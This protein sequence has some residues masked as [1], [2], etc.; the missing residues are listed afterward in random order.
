MTAIANLTDDAAPL[1]VEVGDVRVSAIPSAK[2]NPTV[3]LHVAGV[4]VHMHC[5]ALANATQR[6][7][8]AAFV[9]AHRDAVAAALL[10]LAEQY[11]SRPAASEKPDTA[12]VVVADVEPWRHPVDVAEVLDL[13]RARIETHVHLPPH[14]AAV[15]AG[16]LLLT[17]L[18]DVL[19]TAPILWVYSPMKGCGKS[20]LLDLLTLLAARALKAENA[21]LSALFR[22]AERHRATLI[23]DEIDQ[24]MHG[25]RRSDVAGLLN[26]GFSVGGRFLRSVGD[27]HEPKA[28]NVFG[29]RAVAGIGATLHDT[30]RSRSYRVP[31][32]RAPAGALPVALQPTH[33]GA[34]ADPLRQH[35]ARAALQLSEGMAA[36][37]RDPDATAY[38]ASF[39]GRARDLWLPLLALGAELG[40]PWEMRFRD[41]CLA[42]THAAASDVTDVGELLLADCRRYF[43]DH[44]NV[45]VTPTGLVRWLVEQEGA[46]WSEYRHGR[47]P[48]TTRGLSTLLDRFR[49]HAVDPEWHG[50]G[51]DAK[52]E[53]RYHAAD[54]AAAFGRYL[55]DENKNAPVPHGVP[56][57]P[58]VPSVP[59]S[60]DVGTLGTHGTPFQT[61]ER[62]YL[63][64][65]RA[66]MIDGT[67]HELPAASPDL[68][69]TAMRALLVSVEPIDQPPPDS[70]PM[71]GP[72][73]IDDEYWLALDAA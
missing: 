1:C 24:W 64:M 50:V 68:A 11:A 49:I 20:T 33:A 38:P 55:F 71:G 4:H 5:F 3:Q 69:D 73:P 17:H 8:F 31:M 42:M 27:D 28:F 21:T 60:R 19:S 48:I 57:V 6:A 25:D 34:W 51:C 10:I 54:F 32:E 46:P 35:L 14:G 61:V 58:S 44:V 23:L 56:S 26:A 43:A 52:K 15:V 41:A 63:P 22:I 36:R 72:E 40:A 9:P 37:L 18:L 62:N 59:E 70:M 13:V 16:W 2:G 53:R 30:T 29:F 12:G 45:P 47:D 65:V 66:T 7:K 39:D 67:M